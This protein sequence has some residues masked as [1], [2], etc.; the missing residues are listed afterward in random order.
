MAFELLAQIQELLVDVRVGTLQLC[1]RHRRADTGDHVLALS[2]GQVL[3]EQTVFAGVG[4]TR[5]GHATARVVAHVAKDH[6]ADVDRGAP[7]IREIVDAAVG[8]GIGAK[9]GIEHGL[10][11]LAQL[12]PDVIGE[13]FTQL[14]LV[15]RLEL[16]D[17]LLEH[18]HSQVGV[19][20]ALGLSLVA[21]KDAL[22]LFAIDPLDDPAVHR[23]E[24]PVRVVR[25]T[26][27]IRLGR[28]PLEGLRVQADIQH[29]VHHTGH[30]DASTRSHRD[31]QG[32]CRIAKLFPRL[33]FQDGHCLFDLVPHAIRESFTC[34]I[35]G[36]AGLCCAGKAGGH[37]KSRVGHL[38]QTRALAAQQVSHILV[39][40]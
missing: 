5:K 37:G 20:T 30:R 9:P 10:D 17:H 7:G 15:D 8:G 35:V 25:E 39:A 6:R 16:G 32:V 2:I 40:L 29:G 27:V 4:I 36:Q 1:D 24:P 11:C 22:E 12:I 14:C 23:D 31:E 19:A 28:K 18:V 33:L 3:A 34:I 26:I 13:L 21:V 38:G